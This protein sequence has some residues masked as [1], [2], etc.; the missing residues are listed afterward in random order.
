MDLVSSSPLRSTSFVW[1]RAQG[2]FAR[3]VVCKATFDLV[4]DR[5]QLAEQQEPPHEADEH[6]DDDP[7][8]SLYAP[9]DLA[10]TKARADVILVGRA[11]APGTDPVP[12]LI[13]RLVV[14]GLEKAIEV[15]RDRAWSE[16]GR[17]CEGPSFTSMPLVYE[18]AA[19]GPSTS[20]PV[21]V[22]PDR[23]SPD[24][25]QRL[26]NLQALGLRAPHPDARARIAPVGF[27]PVAPAWPDRVE[28]LG[29]HAAP[30]RGDPLPE[31][32]DLAYF[33]AAPRDQ[34]VEAIAGDERI[35]L[36]HLDRTHARLVTALPGLRPRVFVETR[37]A[38]QE[39]WMRADTLW[40][41]TDRGIC[42]VTWRGVI[43]LERAD[44][45]GRIVVALQG[46]GRALSWA[47][48]EAGLEAGI[49]AGVQA[50]ARRADVDVTQDGTADDEGERTVKTRLP[51]KP[52]L[53]FAERR[54]L[55]RPPYPAEPALV[56]EGVAPPPERAAAGPRRASRIGAWTPPGSAPA[57][58]EDLPGSVLAASNAAAGVTP[59]PAA[60][61]APA[62]VESA[63]ASPAEVVELLWLDPAFAP[64]IRAHAAWKRLLAEPRVRD[65]AGE[66]RDKRKE[67][68]DQRDALLVLRRGDPLGAA[69]LDAELALS[70]QDGTFAPAMVLTEG[71]LGFLFDEREAL[72]ATMALLAP[73][74]SGDRKLKELC[75][76]TGELLAS[77]WLERGTAG[78]DGYVQALRDAFARTARGLPPGYLEAH[79]DRL[80]LEQRR[81]QKRTLLGQEWIRASFVPAGGADAL[82]AYL[83]ESLAKELPLFLRFRARV[84]AEL[85]VQLDQYE[86][87]PIALRVVAL[88][89]LVAPVR[90]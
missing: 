37:A 27:G 8:R 47:D 15:H 40:I 57:P 24:G 58:A 55:P 80:L 49:E 26:P 85:R 31:G 68:R 20:N 23:R 1:R 53:P 14:G 12:S 76:T 82:P 61:P 52:V 72:K 77:P 66:A 64:R 39:V 6:W 75:D 43:P 22:R 28:K 30:H 67:V 19:G 34:Q 60:A 2:D 17:L 25:L 29:R 65:E 9:S 4:P 35:V 36:E 45:A 62:G 33:N 86:P 42:T 7:A 32:L 89:R 46:P 84:L 51:L 5:A 71:G 90:R 70:M 88:G 79:T 69:G 41:E 21:G 74:T 3:T 48:V 56:N 18:R 16:D 50:S 87:S 81:Y 13:A 78:L 59:A 44:A 73:F 10:P 83:P 11:F 63:P 38:P 54:D